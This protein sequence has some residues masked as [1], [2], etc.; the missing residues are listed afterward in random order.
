[1]IKEKNKFKVTWERYLKVARR[2]GRNK[3]LIKKLNKRVQIL[4]DIVRRFSLLDDIM[5]LDE[6]EIEVRKLYDISQIVADYY[7]I[8]KDL[9]IGKTN[10]DR[11]IVSKRQV[12]H[13]LAK[14]YTKN[15]LSNIGSRIGGK[16]HATVLYSDKVVKD[17]LTYDKQFIVEIDELCKRTEILLK[18]K[19]GTKNSE[20]EG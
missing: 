14:R 17:I 5:T 6:N 11:D 15:S 1:M 12:T 7:I 18:A 2:A 8:S 16:N 3:A 4:E 13:Y 20:Y 19:Y 9:I 10:R